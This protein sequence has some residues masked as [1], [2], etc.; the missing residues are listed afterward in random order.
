VLDAGDHGRGALGDRGADR[1]G[2]DLVLGVDEAGRELDPVQPAH[3]LAVRHIRNA[4]ARNH[5]TAPIR[6]LRQ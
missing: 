2:P 3:D 6:V 5:R 4:G 1:V